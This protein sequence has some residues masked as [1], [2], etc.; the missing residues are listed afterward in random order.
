MRPHIE[1]RSGERRAAAHRIGLGLF[2]LSLAL[3]LIAVPAC[4]D[5]F[6]GTGPKT[7]QRPAAKIRETGVESSRSASTTLSAESTLAPKPGPPAY[8]PP[9]FDVRRVMRHVRVLAKRIGPRVESQI[10]E[11]RAAGYVANTLGQYGYAVRIQPVPL[12]NGG[13]SR[14]VIAFKKGRVASQIVLGCHLD[15]KGV[16]PGANDNGSGVG[17]ALELARVLKYR[18]TQPTVAFAFFGAEEMIDANPDHHHFGS[19]TYVRRLRTSQRREIAGMISI[20]MVGYGDAAFARTMRRGPQLL[21]GRL[22]AFGPKGG[23][24]LGFKED[25]G[26]YGQSDHEPFELAGVPAVWLE[27][28]EDPTYHSSSDTTNH[29]QPSRMAKTGRFLLKF[30]ARM[31]RKTVEALRRANKS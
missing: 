1:N 4:R 15:A 10:G 8:V 5:A 21:A 17:V 29:L 16:A 12:P 22:R 26:T 23:L 19:R 30:L 7:R 3:A 24:A 6:E 18:T 28:R 25:T 2:G 9:A 20:D 11:R 27:W 13:Q 31:S 14:N